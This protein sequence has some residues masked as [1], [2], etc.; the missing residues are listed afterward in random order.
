MHRP[1][2]TLDDVV[3]GGH[4]LIAIC[5][6]SACRHRREVDLHLLT[7]RVPGRER[8]V[9]DPGQHFSD[10]LRCP[11]CKRLGMSLWLEPWFAQPIPTPEPNFRILDWGRVPPFGQFRTLATAENLMVARGAYA[12]AAL[13]YQD[14][15]VTMQQGAFV[16]ND[17]QRDGSPKVL[18]PEDYR[19]L[20]DAETG[21]SGPPKPD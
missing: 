8:L 6:N 3:H 7:G 20:R 17:S 13:F 5:R 12:A 15:R 21:L 2:Q 19:R 1:V 4:R 18:T 10:L 11:Q 14:H 9:P 16:L